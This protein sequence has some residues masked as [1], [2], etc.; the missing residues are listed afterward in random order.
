MEGE[1][2]RL[3]RRISALTEKLADAKFA[4]SVETFNVRSLHPVASQ[5]F[6]VSGEESWKRARPQCL[7]NSLVFFIFPRID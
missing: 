2:E 6:S 3:N 4:N 1:R 7:K 5:T